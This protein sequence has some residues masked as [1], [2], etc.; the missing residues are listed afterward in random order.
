MSLVIKTENGPEIFIDQESWSK[1]NEEKSKDEIKEMISDAIDAHNI[2]LP[3]RHITEQDMKESFRTLLN[4]DTTGLFVKGPFY[5][6]YPF[7]AIKSEHYIAQ[8]N[9]GGKASDFFHQK[10]RWLCD[11]MAAP[12]PFRSWSIKKFRMG[13]LN[14]LWSL[15]YKKVNMSILR[16]TIH[17]RKYVASQFRPSA[18]KAIYDY[19]Q[20]QDVLDFSSG[21]GDRLVAFCAARSTKSYVGVDPNERL[22][23]GYKRQ[24]AEYGGDKTIHLIQDGAENTTYEPNSFDL[25]F[26]SPPYYNIERYTQ[27]E[28]QSWKKYR[29][30][31]AWLNQFLFVAIKNAWLALKPGGHM[32]INISDCYSNHRINKICDPL[33]D[34]MSQ[35]KNAQY[36]GCIGLKLSKRPGRRVMSGTEKTKIKKGV[37]AEPM[38]IWKKVIS[39]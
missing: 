30:L 25:I 26:T 15:K 16:T 32:I 21:W 34:Y 2:P 1:L 38:F 17:L 29:K 8:S 3:Y 4:L 10:S 14:A 36:E 27:N 18:A 6:R 33:Y 19:Y 11:G 35:V 31:E 22:M 39:L 12:S 23:E 7:K 5:T 20:A 9:A 28:T 37:F 24:I 13:F